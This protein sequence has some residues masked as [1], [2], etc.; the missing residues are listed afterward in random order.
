MAPVLLLYLASIWVPLR[1]V[2]IFYSTLY[3]IKTLREIM[4]L[5]IQSTV[6]SP[7]ATQIH[8]DNSVDTA[9]LLK[10][11][12]SA[13]Q[14]GDRP[15]ARTLLSRVTESDP[16]CVDA[17]L[18][19]ASISE[20]PEELL[21][22]LQKILEIEPENERALTWKEATCSLLAKTHVQ[23]GIIANEEGNLTFALQSF[24]DAIAVDSSCESAWYWKSALAE[25]ENDKLEYLAKVLAIN[26]DNAD[27]RAA[28]TVIEQARS[29]EK[30]NEV[31]KEAAAGNFDMAC[32][33]LSEVLASEP[34]NCE[35]W[36]LRVHLVRSFEQK[37]DAYD[38]ILQI[39]PSN[40]FAQYGHDFLSELA[41]SI[42]HN[43]VVETASVMAEE[44]DSE[45]DTLPEFVE[46]SE[47]LDQNYTQ[48]SHFEAEE[49]E[50]ET[51]AVED[52]GSV[53]EEPWVSDEEYDV[54]ESKNNE[55]EFEETEER[56]V[57]SFELGS[58]SFVPEADLEDASR[59]TAENIFPSEEATDYY[60]PVSMVAEEAAREVE[61]YV[62]PVAETQE[63]RA[64]EFNSEVGP[65]PETTQEVSEEMELSDPVPSLP[66]SPWDEPAEDYDEEVSA[67]YAEA[68]QSDFE[69]EPAVSGYACPYCAAA[70]ERQSFSCHYCQAALSLSDIESLLS[71][72]PGNLEV[73]RAAVSRMEN[74][75]DSGDLSVEELKSL[76]MGHFNLRNFDAGFAYI[77]EA[78]RREPNDVILA[79]QLNAIA[80]RLDEMRRRDEH[81]ESMPK[82]KTILVV[83]D[84]A[85]VRKLI[86]SK[87]EKSGHQVICAV[88]GVEAMATIETMVPDLVLLDIAM[89]R[90]D[91]YQVCK[92]I[93]ANEAAKDVPVV[94]I[95]GKDGFFDKVRGRMAGTTG[96]ITKPFGPE[97]LMKALETYLLP[98]PTEAE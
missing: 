81:K 25:D 86:S 14:G 30:I 79:G 88:D 78:A 15:M 49:Q 12:V 64:E 66:P 36:L 94:M 5:D 87:L 91:G 41:E 83:D 24:D 34:D 27:A 4:R 2:P 60:E 75:C 10:Q 51:A 3:S 43:S 46:E 16:N 55:P 35:A 39:D 54:F 37:F 62:S 19:L 45:T 71:N 69:S 57:S 80:I 56:P 17:W 32:D 73:I 1:S 44:S 93:R 9:T 11:G 61:K 72:T 59:D 28:V 95:S 52:E 40:L 97:T 63:F 76:G 90:M 74:D 21:I 23:R 85:T 38:H 82:G 33:L 58:V 92:L 48:E 13:A 29:A 50:F 42:K 67:E 47:E 31:K 53:V 6:S 20:Y 18:W 98:E 77:Q 26:S 96:Y 65:T 7:I 89:P 22:F 84:S 68:P 8:A 70:I